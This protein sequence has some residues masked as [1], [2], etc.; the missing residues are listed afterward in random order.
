[1]R[2]NE[3]KEMTENTKRGG[4]MKYV[5]GVAGLLLGIPLSYFTLVVIGGMDESIS[6]WTYVRN[7]LD[8]ID[9]APDIIPIII[10][11]CVVSA[12]FFF[13]AGC[14]IDKKKNA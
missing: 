1:M 10:G 9:F 3:E 2:F 8:F 12:V 4:K 5:L 14:L 13:F 11:T 6:L 7:L